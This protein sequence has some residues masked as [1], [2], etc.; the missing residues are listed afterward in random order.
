MKFYYLFYLAS[1]SEKIIDLFLGYF[2]SN[3]FEFCFILGNINCYDNLSYLLYF[4]FFFLSSLTLSAY[5]NVLRV[6]SQEEL[7][8]EIV[9]IITVLQL[10]TNESFKTKV[11]LDPLKGRCFFS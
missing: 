6:C 9:P 8:G 10:P 3:K 4:L 11:N 7:P 5:L 1:N 2:T